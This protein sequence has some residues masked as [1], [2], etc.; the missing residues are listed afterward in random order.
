[1]FV[2]FYY[3]VCCNHWRPTTPVH[4]GVSIKVIGAVEGRMQS[5]TL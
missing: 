2:V 4:A 3:T 1:M 5:M